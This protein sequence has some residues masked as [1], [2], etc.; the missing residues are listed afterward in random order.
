MCPR[1]DQK[2]VR[3]RANVIVFINVMYW[4]QYI[5]SKY[6]NIDIIFDA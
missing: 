4:I 2:D 6:Y 3:R 5:I 1:A